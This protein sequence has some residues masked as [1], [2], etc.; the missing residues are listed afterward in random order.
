M[1]YIL[2]ISQTAAPTQPVRNSWDVISVFNGAYTDV[3]S[4]FYPNWGQST[5]YEQ[6][7]LEGDMALH[8]NNL[9]YQGI[10][11]NTAINGS[12]MTT[13]HIDYWTPNMTTF[14][15]YL[16]AGGE[17]AVNLTPTLSGWNSADI[18]LATAYPARTLNNIIQFKF[19]SVPFGGTEVYIDNLYFWRPATSLAPPTITGFSVASQLTGA[20][21]FN[22]TAPSS[23]SAGAFSYTSS[24]NLVATISGSTVHIVGVGTS[25][26]TVNQEASSPYAAGSATASLLVTSPPPAAG[27]TT[28]PARNT[29]DVLSQYGS[30]YTNQAGVIF[31]DFGGATI[32]GDVLLGDGSTVKKYTNHSYSGIKVNGTGD[33]NV[34]S[35][36]RLHMDVWSPDFVSFKIKLEGSNGVANEIEVP[37]TKVQGSWNSYDL[38]LSTYTG[39]TLTSLKWIVPVTFGP[40]NTTLYISNVYFYR[41]ATVQPPTLGAFSVPAQ[42]VGT[43]DFAL[44]APTSNSAG[45]F[46]YT[47]SNTNVATIVGGSNLHIVGVGTSNITVT[48]AANGAYGSGTTFASFVASYPLP[49]ASPVP[50]VRDPGTVVSM[51]TGTPTVYA[52]AVNAVRA[53]WTAGTTLTTIPNGTNTCLQVNNLGYL[54]YISDGANF[55]AVGMTKLHVDIYLNAPLSNLFIFLLSNGDQFYQTGNLLAGWNSL[56]INLSNYPGA[57]LSS[58]TGLKFEQNV[59]P[60]IQMYLDNVYFYTAG[61]DPTITGFSVPTK[62]FGDADF[63]LTAPTSNSAGAFTYT[64]SNPA[65]ATIVGGNSIHIVGAGASTITANQAASGSFDVG[66]TTASFV[67]T[68]PELS[69]A[70]PI[71]P[72]RNAWDVVSVFSNSYTNVGSNFYPNWGQGT[73]YQQVSIAGN[74]TLHYTNLDYQ[75]VEFNTPIDASAMTK[76]HIDIWTPNVTPFEVFLIAGGENSITLTPTLSGWNSYDIDLATAYSARTLNN[77]I[78]FKFIKSGFVFHGENNSIY[79]DNLYFWRSATYNTTLKSTF[80]NATVAPNKYLTYQAVTLPSGS[81]ITKYGV[82]VTNMTSNAVGTF[83]STTSSFRL[84][85]ASPS[86]A[87]YGTSF[88][89]RVKLQVNGTWMPYGTAKVVSTAALP[90]TATLNTLCGQTLTAMDQVA[91]CTVVPLATSY[92]F[93]VS[94]GATTT[95]FT[96]TLNNFKLTNLDFTTFP[97]TYATV[98]SVRIQVKSMVN[99]NEVLSAWSTPCS[100]STPASAPAVSIISGCGVAANKYSL[101]KCTSVKYATEYKFVLVSSF[102]TLEVSRPY[103]SFSFNVVTGAAPNTLYT[104]TPSYK[105]YGQWYAG[106]SCD[107]TSPAIVNLSKTGGSSIVKLE[108][109]VSDFAVNSYPNPFAENF[110]LN[111]TSSLEGALQVK[112]YDMLGK[113]IETKELNISDIETLEV[114]NDY[115]SGVYNVV[116]TQGENSKSLRVIKR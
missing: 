30:A 4:N 6:V 31:D 63:A 52:N 113:L 99:G 42:L 40:N 65:V 100:V 92:T 22:L 9:N 10:Q 7:A 43:P 96:N 105:I 95:T 49:G 75:G 14:Q 69:I 76:L 23:N 80:W 28:P 109:V 60:A 19:Q 56:N 45:A 12:A 35:M 84:I 3:G 37:F 114:G 85:D 108:A 20:P 21:D 44:T 50:P 91:Y 68:S 57:D 83:E 101:V 39:V 97:L 71:P 64:S 24:N 41:P 13:L 66:S 81:S 112:V 54:G 107:V 17:N 72:A 46:S 104:V 25:I 5:T 53:S 77:I 18:D 79:I 115:P 34:S 110:K 51:F 61:F 38:D 36:T 94:Q 103:N 8:Y 62:V 11:F 106:T 86:V 55:S 93:E 74:A 73:A 116:V 70:A 98:Y 48:Q 58:I 67:V 102:N 47:S 33:L 111:V 87:S 32:D 89:V 15:V 82:E 90:P 29:W 59:G 16:I 2:G 88:S 1:S 26:I 78:Q 27:P